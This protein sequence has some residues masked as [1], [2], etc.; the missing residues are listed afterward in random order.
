METVEKL[1]MEGS[2]LRMF[3][4]AEEQPGQVVQVETLDWVEE[5]ETGDKG[6]EEL[7]LH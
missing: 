7:K 5:E 4:D 6:E 1:P 2:Q 3:I